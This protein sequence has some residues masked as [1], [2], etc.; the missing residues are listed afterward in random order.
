MR[1]APKPLDLPDVLAF[2]QGLWAV[3]H[4]MERLSKQMGARSGVTGPQR[5]VLRLIT[6]FPGLSAG[7]LATMLH[8]HPSTLTGILYRLDEQG[9]IA[10]SADPHDGRRTIHRPTRRGLRASV[11]STKTVEGAV[12][13]ALERTTDAQRDV[14]RRFLDQLASCLDHEIEQ[15]AG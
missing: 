11:A 15:A 3:V 13:A 10:R 5:L 8:L 7:E 14:T 2:M 6:L 9:L 12:A 1:T 4:R